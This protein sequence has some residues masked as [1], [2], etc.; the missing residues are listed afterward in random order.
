MRIHFAGSDASKEY[1]PVLYDLGVIN[2]LESYWSLKGKPPSPNFLTL[3]DSG[4]F[5][6]RTKGIQI[7]VK[8]YAEYINEHK[9][10]YAF[11]LDT[12]DVPET[13]SNQKY[14]DENCSSCHVLPVYHYSDFKGNTREL[15]QDYAKQYHYVAT[16]GTAGQMLGKKETHEYFK[17]VFRHTE[18]KIKVHG[19]GMTAKDMLELY[20]WF[21]VDSTSWLSAAR[22]GNT[23]TID[24]ELTAAFNAK[25]KHFLV[26]TRQEVLWWLNLEEYLTN[27]WTKRGVIWNS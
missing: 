1:N 5:V 6:A 19:L 18:D 27:L 16:G 9:I 14:L 3:L 22:F 26:N 21:S 15:I 13:L 10:I 17:Y 4:G 7:D 25:K 2:R 8:K 11:N 12:S 20:P 23:N 24:C